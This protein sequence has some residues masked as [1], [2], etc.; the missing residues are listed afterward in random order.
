MNE[1]WNGEKTIRTTSES[2]IKKKREK[3]VYHRAVHAR[4]CTHRGEKPKSLDKRAHRMACVFAYTDIIHIFFF[5]VV[6]VVSV[7]VC[8]L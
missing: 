6:V 5:V 8:I 4:I 3:R 1:K 7:A 2:K